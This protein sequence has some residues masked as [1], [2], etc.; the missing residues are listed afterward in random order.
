MLEHS[1][2]V[3]PGLEYSMLIALVHYAR[4]SNHVLFLD[5]SLALD[6]IRLHL[7]GIIACHCDHLQGLLILSLTPLVKSLAAVAAPEHA[8]NE[9]TTFVLVSSMLLV[10]GELANVLE[11]SLPH[12][13]RNGISRNLCEPNHAFSV[14]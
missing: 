1:R 8:A 6:V 7:T 11:T 4:R 3:F 13:F 2:D 14:R 10:A 5:N 9:I 12:G